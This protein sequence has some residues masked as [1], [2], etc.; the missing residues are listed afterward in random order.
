MEPDIEITENDREE[1]TNMM[2][3]AIEHWKIIKASTADA[4]REGFLTRSGKIYSK[5]ESLHLMVEAHSIDVLLDYL[6]WGLNIIKL[7]W[8]NEMLKVEWR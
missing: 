4:L 7:P 1:S 5:N 2:L 8:M 3:A 6:P